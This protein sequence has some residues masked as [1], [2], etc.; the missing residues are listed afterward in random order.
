VPIEVLRG[1]VRSKLWISNG[2]P[3]R[4]SIVPSAIPCYC[5][6]YIPLKLLVH[7]SSP[8]DFGTVHI[9]CGLWLLAR[10]FSRMAI[11]LYSRSFIFLLI[12]LLYTILQTTAQQGSSCDTE[13][14]CKSGC[15][16]KLGNCGFGTGWCD[17]GNCIDTCNATAECGEYAAVKGK[18]CPLNVCCSGYGYCG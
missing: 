2:I 18:L 9:P 14:P 15:C 5:L 1:E 10:P 3:L 12:V 17:A 11:S 16:N 7:I 13:N 8:V 4:V 6:S